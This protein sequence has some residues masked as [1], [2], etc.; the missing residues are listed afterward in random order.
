MTPADDGSFPPSRR[1][2]ALF[3]PIA[4]ATSVDLEAAVSAC[5]FPLFVW[6]SPQAI[7]RMANHA[8][9]EL[10]QTRLEDLVGRSGFELGLPRSAVERATAALT[11]DDVENLR[12]KSDLVLPNGITISIWIWTRAIEL[13]GERGGVTLL[14]PLSDISRL[15]RDTVAPWRDLIPI[16]VGRIDSRSQ[17]ITISTDIREISGEE[18]A[19]VVGRR[20]ADLVHPEDRSRLLDNGLLP[21]IP[22]SWCQLRIRGLGGWTR[23]CLLLGSPDESLR[24]SFAV[25]GEPPHIESSLA[26][27]IEEL[28]SHLRHIAAEVRAA[29]VV[30]EMGNMASAGDLPAL[31][32]LTSR[33]WEIIARLMRGQRVRAIADALFLSQSTVRNH[34]TS[35]FRRFGVHSQSELLEKLREN[36]P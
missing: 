25:I 23:G 17:I 24:R 6:T 27:R 36:R 22:T 12:T 1:V 8:A 9:A 35:I 29:G 13:D 18:P 16:A 26:Q 31:G 7:V 33:Q 10:L 14:T 15:G 21:L 30:E 5:D 11:S 4:T 32:Q 34:L 3:P 28:E 19:K 2:R 20:L